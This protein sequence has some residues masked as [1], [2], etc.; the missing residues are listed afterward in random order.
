METVKCYIN[1]ET[2]IAIEDAKDYIE[3]VADDSGEMNLSVERQ[4]EIIYILDNLVNRY[5]RIREP[6]K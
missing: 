5:K 4:S 3:Y 6:Y 1:D 2:I